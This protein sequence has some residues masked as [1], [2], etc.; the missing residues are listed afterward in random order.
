MNQERKFV[1]QGAQLVIP[2]EYLKRL[3]G[4]LMAA[5]LLSQIAY[6]DNWSRENGRDGWFYKTYEEWENDLF[7]GHNAINRAKTK[8]QNL[9]VIEVKTKKDALGIPKNHWRINEAG[10]NEWSFGKST[11]T[12]QASPLARN[13]QD[14]LHETSNTS[15]TDNTNKDY[16]QNKSTVSEQDFQRL[17][18]LYPPEDPNNPNHRNLYTDTKG[19][20][21]ALKS[22]IKKHG[23]EAVEKAVAGYV[24]ERTKSKCYFQNFEKALTN[25]ND[26]EIE[27]L[28]NIKEPRQMT[29]AEIDAQYDPERYGL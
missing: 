10:Y 20:R 11:C 5:L 29:Q 17:I 4:D 15:I 2:A 26:A 6:W 21:T 22:L 28:A 13:E 24:A 9:G 23:I 19:V 12:K 18:E 14:D 1:G 16:K 25:M 3:D 27:R 7:V 8:L